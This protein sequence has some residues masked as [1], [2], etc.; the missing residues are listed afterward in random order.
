MGMPDMART[1]SV[2]RHPRLY[3]L[4]IRECEV[5]RL[6]GYRGNDSDHLKPCQLFV[7]CACAPIRGSTLPTV[8]PLPCV[9]ALAAFVRPCTAQAHPTLFSGYLHKPAR[10][11]P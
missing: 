7:G 6:E 5:Y 1:L 2:I 9:H 8:R 3:T 10:Y 11:S 4:V